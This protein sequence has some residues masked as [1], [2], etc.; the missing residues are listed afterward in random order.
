MCSNQ[1]VERIEQLFKDCLQ[2]LVLAST[3]AAATSAAASAQPQSLQQSQQS[4]TLLH[5]GSGQE[6]S[7]Q[8]DEK[9]EKE[10]AAPQSQDSQEDGGSGIA[11]AAGD[12]T[13]SSS[14]SLAVGAGLVLPSLSNLPAS[15]SLVP[16]ADLQQDQDNIRISNPLPSSSFSPLT[17]I[18][19][20]ALLSHVP[21]ITKTAAAVA[22]S[23]N[24]AIPAAVAVVATRKRKRKRRSRH[25]HQP[26]NHNGVQNQREA[27]DRTPHR[28]PH[29]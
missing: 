14:Q 22:S 27:G 29:R 2:S 23:S 4:S 17:E 6:E 8:D 16:V 1:C 11:A 9:D 19:V 26:A 12:A 21:H 28:N 18:L 10:P 7:G 15:T 5:Q 20:K 3:T 24:I 13:F 25:P